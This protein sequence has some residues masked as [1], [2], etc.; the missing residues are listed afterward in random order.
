[1]SPDNF[2]NL[3]PNPHHRVQRRCRLLKDDR[4][5][6]TTNSLKRALIYVQD[7][8]FTEPD[9]SGY[10]SRSPGK[11]AEERQGKG[12]FPATGRPEEA[13]RFAGTYFQTEIVENPSLDPITSTIVNREIL[14][15]EQGFHDL[16]V[17]FADATVLTRESFSCLYSTPTK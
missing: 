14:N 11:Q 4:R 5:L 12:C 17:E 7:V 6:G 2:G 3:I 1:V 9:R 15:L 13:H 8:V 16:S 10:N